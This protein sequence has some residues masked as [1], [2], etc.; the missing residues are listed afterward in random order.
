MTRDGQLVID[1]PEIRRRLIMAIDGYTAIYRKG[2]TPP[3]AVDV[4]RPAA[5]TRLSSRRPW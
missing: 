4:G 5:T 2:C 1:D 3:D